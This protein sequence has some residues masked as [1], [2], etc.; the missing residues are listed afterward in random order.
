M[1]RSTHSTLFHLCVFCSVLA[2]ALVLAACDGGDAGDRAPEVETAAEATPKEPI[3]APIPVPKVESEVDPVAREQIAEILRRPDAFE[4]ARLL[5]E[6][7]PQWE[8]ERVVTAKALLEDPTLNLDATAFDLLVRVWAQYQPMEAS[9]WAVRKASVLFR[10]SA[11]L[12]AF[13]RFAEAD[14]QTAAV[15]MDAWALQHNDLEDVLRAGLVRGWYASGDVAGLEQ[16]MLAKGP[17]LAQ[18]RILSQY[19]RTRLQAEGSAPVVEWAVS[20]PGADDQLRT[21]VYRQMASNLPL[22]DFD[23]A[24]AWCDAHCDGPY[25]NNL[26]HIIARRW[27]RT[28]GPSAL[29][30]LATDYPGVNVDRDLD[31]GLRMAFARW[32]NND[33]EAALHWADVQTADGEPQEWMYPMI[34][35]WTRMLAADRPEDAVHWAAKIRDDQEREIVLSDIARIWLGSDEEAAEAWLASSPLSEEARQKARGPNDRRPAGP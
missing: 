6:L 1:T 4:R 19:V 15:A 10:D 3:R 12:E 11:V 34:P 2:T 33:R 14:P 7:L 22:F 23:A 35:V 29:A 28:D 26:R 31:L 32:S 13:T 9:E 20:F 17:G 16:Y 21:A 18:Q 5:G 30:W 8:A 24:M 25:G 27:V